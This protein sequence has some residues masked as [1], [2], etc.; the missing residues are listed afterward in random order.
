M[1]PAA[2]APH[3]YDLVIRWRSSVRAG[4]RATW[5]IPISPA[6]WLEPVHYPTPELE[7]VLGRRSRALFQ[8]S[9]AGGDRV[10]RVHAGQAT[11]CARAWH[12]QVQRRRQAF[13]DKL[14]DG[15]IGNGYERAFAEQISSNWRASAVTDFPKATPPPL[16]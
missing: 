12:V 5:S 8:N 2:E 11:S 3:L 15:M 10:R 16:R 14:V 4:S 6:R 7:K 13:K 9:D 1:L